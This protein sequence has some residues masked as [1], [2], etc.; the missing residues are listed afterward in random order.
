MGNANFGVSKIVNRLMQNLAY[1]LISSSSRSP[2]FT[3]IIG[4]TG[5]FQTAR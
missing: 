1:M 3:N 5:A 4:Q 2:N